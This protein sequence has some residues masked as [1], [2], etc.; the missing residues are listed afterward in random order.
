MKLKMLQVVDS[1]STDYYHE[2]FNAGFLIL[3]SQNAD[4]II[5][6]ANSSSQRNVMSFIQKQQYDHA[7]S[8][9]ECGSLYAVRKESVFGLLCRTFVSALQN[10]RYL[11]KGGRGPIIFMHNDAFSIYWL[12]IF[13][14]LLK[15]PVAIV[16]HG[17]LE[18]LIQSPSWYKP[19]FFYKYLFELFFRYMP[20][21]DRMHFIVLGESIRDNLRAI[22]PKRGE[23]MFMAIR[24]PYFFEEE[25]KKEMTRGHLSLGTVGAMNVFKGFQRLMYLVELLECPI[26]KQKMTVTVIG[27]LE[28]KKLIYNTSIHF[29]GNPYEGLPR[30]VYVRSIS[31]LDYILF[32]YAPDSYKLIASGAIFD[33]ISVGKPIIALRNDYF[34][35]LFKECGT[36]G[37]LCNT[38]E[39]IHLQILKLIDFPDPEIYNTFLSNMKIAKCLFSPQNINIDIF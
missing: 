37:Y 18:L 14:L 12:S 21:S 29:V 3:C 11:F 17:E 34:D 30:D 15:R 8:K 28:D 35:S 33:A 22:F 19:S 1:Y 38:V 16:C 26:Q 9:I 20:L 36:M 39:E 7:L 27:K 6:H 25:V 4:R 24:H 32:L 13:N 10:I 5:Y 31:K 2:M 23:K